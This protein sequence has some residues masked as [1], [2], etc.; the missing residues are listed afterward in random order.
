MKEMLISLTVKVSK[1]EHQ[2]L[3]Q[4]ALDKNT[5]LQ[6]FCYQAIKKEMKKND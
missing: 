5:T 6:E 1:E 4:I 3:K 2:L